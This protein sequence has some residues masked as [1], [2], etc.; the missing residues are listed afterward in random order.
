MLL[1]DLTLNKL[2]V[3]QFLAVVVVSSSP[4]QD[5]ISVWVIYGLLMIGNDRQTALWCSLLVTHQIMYC[6]FSF[7]G[8]Q[9][10]FDGDDEEEL[11][12]N[13]AA[14]EVSYPR[15]VSREACLICKSVRFVQALDNGLQCNI[16]RL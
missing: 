1:S 16:K 14:G 11:F 4:A 8:M 15:S 7:Y 5:N 2:Q 6:F 3:I 13:I 12:R 10:P 9:P